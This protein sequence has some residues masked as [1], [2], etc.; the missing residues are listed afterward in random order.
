MVVQLLQVVGVAV[1]SNILRKLSAASCVLLSSTSNAETSPWIIDLGVMNYNEQNRNTGIEFIMNAERATEE[2]GA[3]NLG[4]EIDVIT[5]ATPNGASST[6]VPQTFTMAS[7]VGVYQVAA[8]ELPAD[9][10]HMDTRMAIK[11][12]LTDALSSDV[13]IDYNALLS[14]EFDYFA[15]ASGL[16]LA[17][18]FNRKN[19]TL[20]TALNLEYDRVHPVGNTPMP[21]AEMQPSGS[22]QPRG[23]SSLS[24]RIQEYSMGINQVIDRTS[25]AQIRLTYSDFR[26]YLNDGYKILSVIDS[27]NLPTLGATQG[28]IF[29]SRP[30]SRYLNSL[31]LAYKKSFDSGIFDASY[32]HFRDNWSIQSNTYQF[33]YK[34]KLDNRFFIRPDIRFYHQNAAYFYHHSV[35]DNSLPTEYASSD[36]RLA[37][38]DAL[39]IGVEFG[40]NLSFDRKHS[41]TIEYYTQQGNSHPQDAIG[42]QQDQ[43]LFPTL[44]TLVLKYIYAIKW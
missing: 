13:R 24:K 27:T 44:K 30:S 38:F 19:T 7:G 15:I 2:G 21:L 28:Y 5:G 41:V 37:E 17:T 3:L 42:L 43:D 29:E 39:T 33:A 23:V 34:F 1:T 40:K 10:T 32:R 25:L 9:D 31:Y 4:L 35:A 11:A 18:D 12:A 6:N 14:M 22:F 8:N 26:G 36:S 20:I 16:S